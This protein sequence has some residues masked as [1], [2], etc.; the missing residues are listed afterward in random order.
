[1]YTIL[2]NMVYISRNFGR[3]DIKSFEDIEDCARLTKPDTNNEAVNDNK[4]VD[5]TDSNDTPYGSNYRQYKSDDTHNRS[6]YRQYKSTD[7]HYKSKYKSKIRTF[8]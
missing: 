7:T 8:N 4:K 3:F 2:Y 5:T 6:N 1:M